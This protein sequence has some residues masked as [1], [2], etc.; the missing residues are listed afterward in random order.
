[1]KIILDSWALLALISKE[2]PAASA[3]K[4][5]FKDEAGSRVSVHISWINLGEVFCLIALRKGLDAAKIV[6]N[7]IQTLPVRLQVPTKADILTA[8]TIKSKHSL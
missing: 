8:A 5:L 7:D 6:L 1:M 2:E 4:E 3:V